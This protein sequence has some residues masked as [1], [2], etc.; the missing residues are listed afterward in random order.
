[1]VLLLLTCYPR[2]SP[3]HR[4][5]HRVTPPSQSASKPACDVIVSFLNSSWAFLNRHIRRQRPRDVTASF[6]EISGTSSL[7]T[8]DDICT[9]MSLQVSM[10]STGPSTRGLGVISAL[11]CHRSHDIT[12]SLAAFLKGHLGRKLPREVASTV[13]R[14][15]VQDPQDRNQVGTHWGQLGKLGQPLGSC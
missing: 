5:S 14:E 11:R 10:V 15:G 1:M 2:W 13:S 6:Q 7:G 4:P 9:A 12:R 8:S 3:T